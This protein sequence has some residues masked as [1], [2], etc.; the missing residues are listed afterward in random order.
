M[1]HEKIPHVIEGTIIL[2][3]YAVWRAVSAIELL[4]ICLVPWFLL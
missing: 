1:G 4:V 2:A 3:K